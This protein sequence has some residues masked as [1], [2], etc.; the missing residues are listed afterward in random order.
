A[1]VFG[2]YWSKALSFGRLW[3]VPT[4]DELNAFYDIPVYDDYLSGKDNPKLTRSSLLSRACVKLADSDEGGQLFRL[5]AD[6]ASD[7]LRTPFR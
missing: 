2:I 6:S 3:P 4:D 5:K 7:R 1:V